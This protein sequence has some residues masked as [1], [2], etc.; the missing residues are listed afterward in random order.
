M[1]WYS[2][3]EGASASNTEG[4]S[5]WQETMVTTTKKTVR[6]RKPERRPRAD[7][8]RN[9]E[10]L[11]RTATTIF[12]QKGAGASLEEIAREAGLGI[13][14]LYRHFPT[15]D[16]LVE[17]V[18]R[19]EVE[20]LGAAA[21]R[22][23]RQETPVEALRSW[24]VL[25]LDHLATKQGM[26][27]ALQ[28]LVGGPSRLYASS[29]PVVTRSVTMLVDSAVSRGEIRCAMSPLDLLRAIAGL[30]YGATEPHWRKNA[31]EL[32][33]VLVAGMQTRR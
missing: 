4:A 29:T 31:V 15:R 27:T 25:F 6:A 33:D 14:T 32:I 20:Q 26:S 7:A 16:A 10:Q 21:E 11:V 12:A 5:V 18:Y 8:E 28:S 9:R 23:A 24:L 13:G 3:T 19:T 22:L 30:A 17:A 2:E 1:K